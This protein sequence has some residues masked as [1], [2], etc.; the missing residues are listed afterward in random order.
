MNTPNYF[1]F[2]SLIC[3]LL[4]LPAASLPSIA[5][6]PEKPVQV[7]IPYGPGS[8]TDGVGRILINAMRTA[9]KADLVPI[10]V[11]GA[12]GTIGTARAAAATPDGYTISFNPVATMTI[13]PHLRP[14]PYG[15]DSFE[16]ICM[17]VDNATSITVA[18][19]SPYKS[20]E[21]LINAAKTGKVVAV[22]GA[23]GSMP[24][25]VQAALARAYGVKFIYL[26]AGGGAQAA[27]SVLGGEAAFASDTSAMATT[28]GLRTLAVL[29]DQRLPELPKVP[30]MKELGKDLNISIWFGL[31]APK[32]TP[33]AV[34]K[35]LSTGC[36]VASKDGDFKAAMSKAD[37]TVRYM[38]SI[39]FKTYFNE[40]FDANKSMLDLIGVKANP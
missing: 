14:L 9:M 16:P 36:E 40:Q 37:F 13:Q 35:K 1:K 7:I 26:P 4:I 27:K 5:A 3:A 18:P 30:T 25:I 15:K 2:S 22:G 23:P 10:N 17:V 8:N 28:H 12:G 6:Y 31:F 33:E 24:H 19:D 11:S 20:I 34:L 32:G 21:D 29:S 39:A 38:D